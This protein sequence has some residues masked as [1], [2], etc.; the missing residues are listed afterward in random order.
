MDYLTQYYKNRSEQLQQE[1]NQLNENIFD[2]NYHFWQHFFDDTIGRDLLGKGGGRNIVPNG[3]AGPA[4]G[5]KR[6]PTRQPFVWQ[7]DYN[8]P[9]MPPPGL[10]PG[11]PLPPGKG[12]VPQSPPSDLPGLD[13]Q[14]WPTD[15]FGNPMSEYPSYDQYGSPYYSPISPY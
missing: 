11:H 15:R 3:S 6:P 12:R 13:R 4:P 8:K 7:Q 5:S 10:D 1:L 9:I 14:G 2:D